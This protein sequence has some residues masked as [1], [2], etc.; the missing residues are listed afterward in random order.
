MEY[1]KEYGE[2]PQLFFIDVLE[3]NFQKVFHKNPPKN[4]S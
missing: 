3:K 4:P 2:L 1:K